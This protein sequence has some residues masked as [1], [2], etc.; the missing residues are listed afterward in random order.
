MHEGLRRARLPARGGD[1]ALRD[2]AATGRSG[3]ELGH[4]PAA[5]P[6]LRRCRPAA[7]ALPRR[8]GGARGAA[9]A[10]PGRAGRARD[11]ARLG[12]GRPDGRR[13]DRRRRPLLRRLRRSRRGD[14]RLRAA[15]LDRAD[16]QDPAGGR[17]DAARQR[18]GGAGDGRGPRQGEAR[19]EG[20]RD[21]RALRGPRPRH[22]HRL[23]RRSRP[24]PRLHP[25]LVGPR[26]PHLH[27]DRQ[28]PGPARPADPARDLGLRR[29][30]LERPDQELQPRPTDPRVRQACSTSCW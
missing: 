11:L 20:E 16:D 18:A 26:H 14:L 9:R 15:A 2:G 17:A 6:L 13:A 21:R 10:R 7:A 22:R 8:R 5:V 25:G 24:R 3:R 30:L 29:R 23:P 12:G 4:R 19:H 1:D 27:P 28:P